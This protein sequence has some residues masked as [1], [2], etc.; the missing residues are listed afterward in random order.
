MS[1][2]LRDRYS[3]KSRRRRMRSVTSHLR[4]ERFGRRLERLEPRQMLT[5][6]FG[7]GEGEPVSWR[8]ALESGQIRG[9]DPAAGDEMTEAARMFYESTMPAELVPSHLYI[10]DDPVPLLNDAGEEE[11]HEAIVM[12]WNPIADDLLSVA[13]FEYDYAPNDQGPGEDLA[14]AT[15]HFSVGVP[16]EPGGEPIIWDV[17]FELIDVNGN[18]RGWF[19]PE[20]PIGWHDYW[21]ML[22]M[23]TPQEGWEFFESPGFD[24]TQVETIRLDEAGNAVDFPA[25]PPGA[26]AD[27][28]DWNAW[29]HLRIEPKEDGGEIHGRKF[30]D[31][32]GNGEQGPNEPGLE[33][34]TIIVVGED[35]NGNPIEGEATTN[36]RGEYWITGLPAGKYE[37]FEVIQDG[38]E[39][40]APIEGGYTIQL[41]VGDVVDGIDFGNYVPGSLHGIKFDDLNVN[42]QLDPGEPGIPGV[43]I[44]VTGSDGTTQSMLTDEAGHF[45]FVGLRPD[46]YTV[47]EI[48]PDGSFPTTQTEFTLPL[49]SR[50][51]LVALEGQAMLGADDLRREVVVGA[52]LIFGNA[53]EGSI[54][55]F[56][57]FDRNGNGVRD[58]GEPGVPGVEIVATASDGTEWVTHTMENGEFWFEWL[59]PGLTLYR[60]G[61]RTARLATDNPRSARTLHREWHRMGR[62]QPARD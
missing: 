42:G 35:A 49:R 29:N 18:S 9:V 16:G 10:P 39:Q 27:I 19:L 23:P 51:E 7:I 12:G 33:G 20:P 5:A 41:G 62:Q 46:L 30:E 17:S 61:E 11:V 14:N 55:G 48:P 3:S 4:R 60:S 53:F 58:P 31:I 45:W 15:A 13:A 26:D 57:F 6:Y 44:V 59:T 47:S 21:I 22:D 56:K 40:S 34:W 52:E 38:W 50:E 32:D 1:Q 8:E 25:P 28:W 54:H 43:T 2:A 24:I 36:A 37:V